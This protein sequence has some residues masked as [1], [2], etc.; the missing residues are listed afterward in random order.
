[1]VILDEVNRQLTECGP[2][3]KGRRMSVVATTVIESAARPGNPG[4]RVA[5]D[6]AEEGTDGTDGTDADG[7]RLWMKTRKTCGQRLEIRAGNNR[8][9][10]WTT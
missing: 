4:D 10:R 3:L 7:H 2:K 8:M 9:G 6:R 1:V 5:V